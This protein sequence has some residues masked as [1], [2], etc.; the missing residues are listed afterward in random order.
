MFLT[1]LVSEPLFGFGLSSTLLA[2]LHSSLLRYQSY[3]DSLAAFEVP[4]GFAWKDGI[5]VEDGEVSVASVA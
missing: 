1:P 5:E 4:I 2:M 3:R